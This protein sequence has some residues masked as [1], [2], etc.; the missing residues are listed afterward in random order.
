MSKNKSLNYIQFVNKTCGSTSAVA[1]DELFYLFEN[2]YISNGIISANSIK[3]A[4]STLYPELDAQR[5]K[6]KISQ[7]KKKG[8]DVNL[9]NIVKRDGQNDIV[10]NAGLFTQNGVYTAENRKL[11]LSFDKGTL[12]IHNPSLSSTSMKVSESLD[13][14]D[15]Y[16]IISSIDKKR[17]RKDL[18][19]QPLLNLFKNEEYLFDEGNLTGEMDHLKVGFKHVKNLKAKLLQG[20]EIGALYEVSSF[21]FILNKE[22]IKSVDWFNTFE[23]QSI[24]ILLDFNKEVVGIRKY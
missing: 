2:G 13:G 4:F 22:V 12:S 18:T 7:F 14:R 15:Y 11:V 3:E 24:D 20:V 16:T 8:S 9:F 10:V 6:I 1:S 21:T 23:N 17:T 5:L 19:I